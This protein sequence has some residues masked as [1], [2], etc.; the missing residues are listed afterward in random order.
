VR[1]PNPGV[2]E[3]GGA[4]HPD[5]GAPPRGANGGRAVEVAQPA[6]PVNRLPEP[7]A[8]AAPPRPAEGQ[9]P[10]GES[11][12]TRPETPRHDEQRRDVPREAM[13]EKQR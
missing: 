6:P 3:A 5:R 11:K 8:V 10:P 12:M 2:A 9:R 1:L 4:R 7:A 13:N